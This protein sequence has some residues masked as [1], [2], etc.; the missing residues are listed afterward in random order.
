[1]KK[2]RCFLILIV[3]LVT[4]SFAGVEWATKITTT[5]KKKNQHSEMTSHVY[6][7][8]RD[9]KQVF[10]NVSKSK[11]NVYVEEGYWLYKGKENM[12]YIVND[13]QKT[14]TPVSLDSLLQ[15]TG[16]MGKL[17]KISIIDPKVDVKVLAREK[18][19]GYM[20]NHI[21]VR[22][23][24]TMKMKVVVLKKTMIINEAKE[25]WGSPNI[26]YLREINQTFLNKDF[27]TGFEDLDKMIKKEMKLMKKIG[28]PLKIITHNI[29][30]NKKGKVKSESTTTT[31]VIKIKSRSFPRSFFDVPKDYKV[32]EAS[33]GPK[34]L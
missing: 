4:A 21:R 18:V 19:L 20:C 10:K 9:L 1:M 30:K 25:I 16:V 31:E 13:K 27:R 33:S 14:V 32:I 6:A 23:E 34:F 3:Y 24:Y 11:R 7:Q 5:G 17:V 29:Q 22:S 28:F 8:G 2:I 12:M 26:R 15:M